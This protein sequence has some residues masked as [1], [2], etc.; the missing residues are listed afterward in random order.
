M[1]GQE[2]FLSTEDGGGIRRTSRQEPKVVPI[3]IRQGRLTAGRPDRHCADLVSWSRRNIK[4]EGHRISLGLGFHGIE[5]GGLGN[6]MTVDRGGNGGVIEATR[7]QSCVHPGCSCLGALQEAETVARQGLLLLE[8]VDQLLE[9][10]LH[11]VVPRHSEDNL[12]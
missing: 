9:V 6:R 7:A 4:G 8:T 5:R 11:G 12:P 3:D 2:L 1:Q 10:A